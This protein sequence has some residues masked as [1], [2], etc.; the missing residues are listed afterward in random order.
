MVVFKIR[1][2]FFAF[3]SESALKVT[4]CLPLSLK[5]YTDFRAAREFRHQPVS[6]HRK[7]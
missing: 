3:L 5:I 2:S 1:Q 6:T 4:T 7:R